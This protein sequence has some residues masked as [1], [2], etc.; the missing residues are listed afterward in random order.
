MVFSVCTY[1]HP[2]SHVG[3]PAT[4]AEQVRMPAQDGALPPLPLTLAPPAMDELWSSQRQQRP[5]G[6]LVTR[7]VNLSRCTTAGP[8][9]TITACGGRSSATVGRAHAMPTTPYAAPTGSSHH[10]SSISLLQR[11]RYQCQQS[12]HQVQF[13]E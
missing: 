2:L 8:A 13:F 3:S 11:A 1:K 7:Q 9:P 6:S 5:P 10:G 12:S 4:T